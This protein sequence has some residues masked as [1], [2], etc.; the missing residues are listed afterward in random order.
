ML[1]EDL[2]A[3][4]LGQQRGVIV[5]DDRIL[6]TS[7]GGDSWA[8]APVGSFALRG[9]ADDGESMWAVGLGGAMLRSDDAGASWVEIES[10]T[11]A[12]LWAIGHAGID[13]E[14][15]LFAIGDAGTILRHESS[16]WVAIDHDLDG[17]LRGLGGNFMV[18]REGLVIAIELEEGSAPQRYLELGRDPARGDLWD[19]VDDLAI[20]DGSRLT[21]IQIDWVSETPKPFCTP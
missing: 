20:G 16:D 12:D 9:V 18:G 1:G 13:A 2:H 17:D 3:L 10:P 19:V 15:G 6:Y 21:T 7:D 8:L 5:G 4:T 14:A 11:Q